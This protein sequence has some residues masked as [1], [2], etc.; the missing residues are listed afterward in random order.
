MPN[1][2]RPPEITSR[3]LTILAS[4]AGWRNV[5]QSTR[6]PTRNVVVVLEREWGDVDP[7]LDPLGHARPPHRL[8]ARHGTRMARR[9]IA[10]EVGSVATDRCAHHRGSGR[11]GDHDGDH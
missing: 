6:C 5:A 11:G 4:S 10:G 1:S 3:L 7:D 8:A 2:R 9:E